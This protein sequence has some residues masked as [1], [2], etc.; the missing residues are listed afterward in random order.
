MEHELNGNTLFLVENLKVEVGGGILAKDIP[1][2]HLPGEVAPDEMVYSIR[3]SYKQYLCVIHSNSYPN[4]GKNC[5]IYDVP[6]ATGT[7]YKNT[8]GEWACSMPGEHDY[9]TAEQA[10]PK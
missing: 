2:I 8:F 4:V 6:K 10:P 1:P 5:R 7:R 9:G 3:E